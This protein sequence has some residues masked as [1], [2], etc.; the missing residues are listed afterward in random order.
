[1]QCPRCGSHRVIS[2]KFAED[3]Y[4]KVLH[5][6]QAGQHA[7][8]PVVA[9]GAMVVAGVMKLADRFVTADWRCEDCGHTW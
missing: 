9:A 1:M 7:G 2:N 5:A 6:G 3:T 4:K 8:Y